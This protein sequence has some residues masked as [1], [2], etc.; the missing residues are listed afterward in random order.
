[1]KLIEALKLAQRTNADTAP[2][3]RVFLACGF[4]A[5]HLRTFLT[6]HLRV[7]RPDIRPEVSTGLFGDLAGNLERL[8]PSSTDVVVIMLEWA[9]LD[10]RLG[11]RS[12]GG[13][14]PSDLLDVVKSAD[15]VATRLQRAIE[16]LSG[17][18]AIVICMPTLPLPPAFITRP[19]EL[20]LEEARMHR[21]VASVA[22]S[23]AQ[24]PKV[25]IV[26]QQKL[27][28]ASSPPDRY[29]IKSDL[30]AGFP[31]TL[32]HA[33]VLGAMLSGLVDTHS[34]LKAIITDLDDTLWAGIVGDDGVDGISWSLDS[35]S[36]MHGVYQQFLSS[37]ASTGVLIGVASKNDEDV[38]TQ[39]FR[40][41][42]L[43]LSSD[44][45]YPFEVHWSRKSES[46]A[47]IL[48]TWNIGEDSVVFIDDNPAEIAEVQAAFPNIL[49]RQFH[50]D[51]PRKVWLLLNELRELFGKSVI[52][53]EDTLRSRSIR[54]SAAWRNGV[55]L[56]GASAEDFFR[57][58]EPCIVL[59]YGR[60]F[61][62]RRALEL[63]NKT[64]QFNLNGK[65]YSDSEWRAF[66]DDPNAFLLT[67]TYEDKFGALGKIAAMMGTVSAGTIHV[68]TWVM[69]CRAFSRR[70]EHQILRHLF[71][72]CGAQQITFEFQPTPRNGPLQD[73]FA[74]LVGGQ[75]SNP[76]ML[77]RTAFFAAAPLLF[78]RVEVNSHV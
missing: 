62:D 68:H 7:R 9:D 40:R 31:Y 13:W 6:A 75:L 20:G 70:I 3:L 67:A 22:E 66:F 14:H 35:H 49:C 50:K 55:N 54:E 57:S 4:T 44:D 2:S 15:A 72:E 47:R 8:N 64:N 46:V 16:A 28:E 25:R 41:Q 5:L 78:H 17:Q 52:S 32:Q 51:D 34:P 71:E 36:Q 60:A 23:L 19:L 39:A 12:L 43:M 37:L 38:V 69:S 24:L 33:S 21:I 76:V 11:I 26:N 29:D 30:Q 18:L 42:D 74:G 65:R 73:F 1:M 61:D 27:A 10:P 59:D 77:S 53:T 45:I 58:A 56:D 48:R 63:V